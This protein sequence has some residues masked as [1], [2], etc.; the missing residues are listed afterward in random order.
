MYKCHGLK[1]K[2]LGHGLDAGSRILR[3]ADRAYARSEMSCALSMRP[4]AGGYLITSRTRRSGQVSSGWRRCRCSTLAAEGK[5]VLRT[6]T[7]LCRASCC[8]CAPLHTYMDIHLATYHPIKHHR[9][10]IKSVRLIVVQL[11]N[12]LPNR[13][14]FAVG[15]ATRHSTGL[16]TQ[17]VT[18]S[19]HDERYHAIDTHQIA[20][21]RGGHT[22]A[23]A[24][25]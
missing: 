23:A 12:D 3:S 16:H 4:H 11:S 25:T 18:R 21:L 9:G 17:H 22:A 20:I 6:T 8:Y 7:V 5:G 2:H 13:V 14:H 10:Q 1:T 15:Y 24:A 19:R